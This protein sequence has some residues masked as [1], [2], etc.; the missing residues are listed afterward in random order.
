[1]TRSRTRMHAWMW[2]AVIAFTATRLSGVHL[3]LCFDGSEPPAAVHMVDGAVHDDA[4]HRETRHVDQD[5]SVFDALLAKKDDSSGQLAAVSPGPL[6]LLYI[7]VLL[8][9]RARA[10]LS[11]AIPPPPLRLRPPL[12]GPPR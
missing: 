1:M 2:L 6:L 5:V 3:H 9:Q 8:T 10:V 7:P 12:R 11:L 4:H